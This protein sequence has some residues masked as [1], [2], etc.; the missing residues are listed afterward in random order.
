[1][2][3]EEPEEQDSLDDSSVPPPRGSSL[4]LNNEGP[5]SSPSSRSDSPGRTPKA[6][7]TIQEPPNIP[8]IHLPD[9]F[10]QDNLQEALQDSIMLSPKATP[11]SAPNSDT[12]LGGTSSG[13]DLLLPII[14]YAIVKAN[15]ERLV[16]HL[17]YTQRYRAAICS[18]GEAQYAVVNMTAAVEFLENVD[19]ADLG[20]SSETVLR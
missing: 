4:E 11:A 1:M 5:I 19:L 6:A 12:K 13:A 14:I 20:L 2:I 17:L 8:E 10:E 15:P 3:A 18:T 7:N 9:S 16:S